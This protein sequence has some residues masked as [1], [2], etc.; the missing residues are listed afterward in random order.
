MRAAGLRRPRRPVHPQVR[1]QPG[2]P[3]LARSQLRQGPATINQIHDPERI[4]YP[5]RRV[6][7]RG[8]GK[9]EQVS[10]EEALRDIG[11]RI[12]QAIVDGR[13]DEVMYH[14]GRPGED[15][16]A[17]RVLQAWGVDGHNSH[18]NVCSSGGRTGYT[19]WMGFDRPSP[20]YANAKTIV[21]LSSHLET[22]HYFNPHAQRI[23]EARKNGAKVAVLDV[24]LS[25][26]A[27]HADLWLAPWPGSEAAIFLAVASYLLRERKIHREYLERW[28]N[29]D[30]SCSGC[31]RRP[32]D[33]FSGV[34]GAADRG[35]RALHLRVRR[36]RGSHRRGPGPAAGGDGGRGRDRAGH[37]HLAVGHGRQP[38]RLADHP[39]P[40]LP[41]RPHRQRRHPGR[42]P[43]QRLGQVH[44]ALPRDAAAERGLE[45]EALADRVPAHHERDVDPAAAPAPRTATGDGS[46]S[47]SAGSTTRCGSTRTASPGS[48]CSPT[49]P[50]SGCTS[51]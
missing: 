28:V 45:R 5:L 26:T 2:P 24:R 12:R 30:V 36:G 29:W 10:W 43:P 4:L 11:G 17:E 21:L 33:D 32:A 51:R 40:V 48:T 14:V 31:T 19:H 47:T 9:F 13:T 16:F 34:P 46:R 39:Q 27:S 7:E 44:R 25:N 38:G 50:R 20:D 3:R 22:G 37:P 18:T 35:L 1:G 42:H 15:G 8:S 41:Q 6:G 23:M 49:S